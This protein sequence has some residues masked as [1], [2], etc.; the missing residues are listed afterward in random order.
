MGDS[1]ATAGAEKSIL[2]KAQHQLDKLP[3]L[4]CPLE[5]PMLDTNHPRVNRR[6]FL[7][8]SGLLA[9]STMIAKNLPAQSP[10]EPLF[11]ISLAQWTLVRELRRRDNR[12]SRF[13][14][15]RVGS[16]HPCD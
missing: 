13:R 4:T 7:A 8:Q 11:K 14:E 6:R 1:D 10:S 15:G 3:A 2:A 5:T 12:Q 16:R 9:G